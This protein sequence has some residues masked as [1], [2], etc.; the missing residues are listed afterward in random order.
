MHFRLSF[1]LNYL[2][3]YLFSYLPIVLSVVIIESTGNGLNGISLIHQY[4]FFSFHAL[5]YLL[6][7]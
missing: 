3:T 6:L 7:E 1:A 2:L 4:V 5:F